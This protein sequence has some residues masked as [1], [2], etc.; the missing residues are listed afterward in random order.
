MAP[1]PFDADCWERLRAQLPDLPSAERWVSL[2]K[3]GEWGATLTL[4]NPT[5]REL[6]IRG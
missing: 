5:T 2:Q 6:E 3:T 4:R 1:G